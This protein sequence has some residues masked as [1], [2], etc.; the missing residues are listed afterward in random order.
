MIVVAHAIEERYA[1]EVRRL[2]ISLRDVVLLAEISQRPG[3]SQTGLAERVGLSRSRVS[4]Q[5]AVLDTAGYVDRDINPMDLRRRKLYASF[6]GQRILAEAAEQLTVID[7]GWLWA[8]A[9]R[10]RAFFVGALMRLPPAHTGRL[11]Y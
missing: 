4:E 10:E 2:G 9:H 7:R 6:E 1:A 8:L 3:I 11:E 5:L